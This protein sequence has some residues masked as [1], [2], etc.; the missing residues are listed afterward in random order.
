MDVSS[1]PEITTD[2]SCVRNEAECLEETDLATDDD[3]TNLKALTEKLRLETRRPSYLEWKARLEVARFHEPGSGDG[4]VFQE[5]PERKEVTPKETEVC[6]D[7]FHS[8]L[9]SGVLKGFGN[10]DEALKWLRRELTDMRLQ[11]QQL[12]RQLMRLRSD[13]NKLKIEQ[14]CHLHR[15]M[16]N[17]ATFGLEE[18]D[19]LSDLLFE[20]PTT[21]GLGLSA[22]LRL[23]GVTKMNINSRRFSLC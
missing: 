12:A 7:L 5:D 4:Q 3:L 2:E 13:I 16:L 21:P 15:R 11:D 10:L 1:V 20:C 23:I 18:R 9:S 22:P 8:K 17:D 14:T 19:E 6:P